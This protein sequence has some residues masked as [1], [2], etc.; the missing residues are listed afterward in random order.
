LH[1][2]HFDLS[3]IYQGIAPEECS[4][5]TLILMLEQ[6]STFSLSIAFCKEDEKNK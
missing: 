2:G 5:F 1:K 6:I 3:D 4:S